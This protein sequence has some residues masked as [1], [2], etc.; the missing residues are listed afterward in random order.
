MGTGLPQAAAA[1]ATAV[2][3]RAGF[4]GAAPADGLPHTGVPGTDATRLLPPSRTPAPPRDPWTEPGAEGM[5]GTGAISG[6][7]PDT[8][9]TH[10]PHEVTVQLD[11]VQLGAG[12]LRPV[13]G[14]PGIAPGGSDGPVFVDESGRRSRTFRR[15]GILV[16]LAC[17]VYAVVIVATMLSGNSSAPWLPVPDQRKEQPAGQVDAPLLPTASVDTPAP[18]GTDTSTGPS[19]TPTASGEPGDPGTGALPSAPDSTVRPSTSSAPDP[20]VSTPADPSTGTGT[21]TSSKPD[22][23]TTPPVVASPGPSTP[24]GGG[25]PDFSPSPAGGV[26]TVADGAVDPVV[27]QPSPTVPPSPTENV[28]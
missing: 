24:A 9:H 11:A 26:G 3:P 4:P 12:G 15:I 19:G 7:A 18:S 13:A 28:A 14:G 10:D 20:S 1:D 8:E 21:G 23:A 17:A 27:V 25:I 5:S 16:G 6:A 2:L 22:P